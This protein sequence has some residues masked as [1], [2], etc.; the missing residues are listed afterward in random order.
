MPQIRSIALIALGSNTP[1]G[2]GDP[3]ETVEK[4]VAAIAQSVGVIRGVSRLYATPAFP[5]GS[6]PD[7]V[8][9]A[10]AV[11]TGL[12]APRVIEILHGIEA[13]MGRL[14]HERW[15][16]RT[17]D[18]DLIALGD[19]LLPDAQTHETWR[20][21]PLAQQMTQTPDRLIVPHPRVQERAFVLVPLTDVAP[22]WVH[23]ALNLSVAQ[24]LAALPDDLKSEVVA[25]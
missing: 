12:S 9:A 11:S 24:M 13:Q 17:L 3:T 25:L 16:P 4:A 8:N 14:R 19:R 6:G 7:F 10:L 20:S 2:A 15:A 18:L 23:P 5:V 21:M 22:D 1:S